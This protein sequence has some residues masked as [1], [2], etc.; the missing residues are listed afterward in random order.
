[1]KNNV[2][3]LEGK[4]GQVTEKWWKQKNEYSQKVRM[5]IYVTREQQEEQYWRNKVHELS[6]ALAAFHKRCVDFLFVIHFKLYA[7][8]HFHCL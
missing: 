5:K 6:G 2:E 8:F 1:M 7:H 3:K 4:W